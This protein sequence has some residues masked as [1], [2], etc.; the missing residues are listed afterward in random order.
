MTRAGTWRA[1]APTEKI[2][3]A[4]EAYIGYV[5]RATGRLDLDA[6]AAAYA[7]VCRAYPQLSA[8]LDAGDDGP[9]FAESDA[10]PEVRTCDGDPERPLTGVELDQYRALSALN[11]VRD[12]D[13][14]S[15]CLLTHHSIADADHSIAVLADLWSC[16]T[17]AVQGTPFDLPRH[18]YPRSL[19]D[20]LAERG[21]RSAPPGSGRTPPPPASTGQPA[22][23]A[24][25]GP[26]RHVVQHR[27]TAAQST[28][29]A[30][31]GHRERVTI[32]GL[33][34]GVLLLVEAEL[35]DLPV[36]EL[37]YRFTVNLRSHLTPPVAPTEGTNVLGGVGFT[38]TDDLRPDA[39]TIGR[40]IGERLRAGLADGSIQR[41]LLDL[42][43]QP[44]PGAKPWDPRTAP[45][46][47]SMMNWGRVPPMRTP[48]DLRLTSFRSASSMRETSA[49]GGYVVNTFEDR[50]G[51][52]LAWPEGDA[53]LPRRL[54]RLRE[55]LSELT[56]R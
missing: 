19:E 28:A 50:I 36:T 14:A 10:R 11:V 2:H 32:N 54:D 4:R 52:D 35:R 17:D 33:L 34:A 25:R 1:L 7:A 23:P 53:E 22:A 46:V 20:L 16:Y 43:S 47:V 42:V 27:M 37:V 40:A 49:M 51:I 21:V 45:A 29:L 44:P 3:V 6:L 31:L 12:G 26:A 48:D 55:R 41:S 18:P 38:A 13:D 8:R 39:V 15:V 24:P 5:V 30:E 9:F 56:L